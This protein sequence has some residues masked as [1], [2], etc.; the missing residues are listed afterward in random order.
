MVAYNLEESKALADP[1]LLDKIDKLFECNVG[2][3]VNLPQLVVVG[4]QSS[5]KSSVLEGLTGL[6]FPRDSGL[7][8]RHAT[9]IIFRRAEGGERKISASIIPGPDIDDEE[10]ISR[11]KEWAFDDIQSLSPASFSRMM[12]EV[13]T[14]RLKAQASKLTILSTGA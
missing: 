4:D 5:G 14:A 13:R 1:A 8:T 6:G 12:K 3:Y 2:E 10:H 11:L 7:C 9:Q